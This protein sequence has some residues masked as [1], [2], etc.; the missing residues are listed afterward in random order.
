MIDANEL[1]QYLDEALPELSG[2]CRKAGCKNAYDYARQLIRYTQD[3]LKASNTKAACECMKLVEKMY[4]HGS[5][6]IKNAIENVYVYSFTSAFFLNG[7]KA[8]VSEIMPNLLLDLYRKQIIYS[9]L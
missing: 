1:P 9:H 3:K 8:K 5:H 2:I 6:A 4:K 7:D